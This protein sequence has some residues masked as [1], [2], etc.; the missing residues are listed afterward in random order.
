MNEEDDTRFILDTEMSNEA[1][2]VIV[3]QY[4][5]MSLYT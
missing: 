3:A 2:A 4:I 5:R 1:A